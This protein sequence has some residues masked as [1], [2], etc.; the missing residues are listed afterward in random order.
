MIAKGTVYFQ[1]LTDEQ[2][3]RIITTEEF[4]FAQKLF[5]DADIKTI[6]AEKHKNFIVERV[7]QRGLLHDFYWLLKLYTETEITSALKKSKSLDKKTIN[8]CSIFFEIPLNDLNASS[9]Y[10]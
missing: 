5:W 3:D 7:M 9:Y 2:R 6:D 4:P 10:S 8:F 1:Y